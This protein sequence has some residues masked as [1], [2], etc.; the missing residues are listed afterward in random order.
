MHPV[1]AVLLL[2]TLRQVPSPPVSP[3]PP[4]CEEHQ[5]LE[6]ARAGT[7]D[8]CI[9]R[10]T[11][12]GLLF[13]APVTVELEDEARFAEVLRG[14]SGLGLVPPADL[15]PG[16]RFRL[17]VRFEQESPSRPT[18]LVLVSQSARATR[19]VDVFRDQRSREALARQLEEERARNQRLQEE[20]RALREQLAP[21]PPSPRP[22]EETEPGPRGLITR[23]LRGRPARPGEALRAVHGHSYRASGRVGVRLLLVNEGDTPWPLAGA[24]LSGPRGEPLRDVTVVPTGPLKPGEERVVRVE[25]PLPEDVPLEALRLTLQAEDTRAF[26][27]PEIPLP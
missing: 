19:Q 20:N 11:L 15:R 17:T 4:A 27:L 21:T 2:L 14:R 18:T 7:R 5:T 24:E 1:S 9:A 16:E 12:T 25:A 13:D 6:L 22:R 26:T 8:I 10:G 3:P 23:A